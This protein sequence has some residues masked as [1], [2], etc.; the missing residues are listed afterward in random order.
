MKNLLKKNKKMSRTY[1]VK[2]CHLIY[3]KLVFKEHIIW[4]LSFEELYLFQ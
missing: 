2:C 1:S 4:Y 3:K